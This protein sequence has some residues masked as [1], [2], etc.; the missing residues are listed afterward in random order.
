MSRG[1][2]RAPFEGFGRL[3]FLLLQLLGLR[4][5]LGLWLRPPVSGSLSCGPS[6][7]YTY[8]R[9][10]HHRV[11]QA[12]VIPRSAS[13]GGQSVDV[14]VAC[15]LVALGLQA[16]PPVHVARWLETCRASVC[17]PGWVSPDCPVPC[18]PGT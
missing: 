6:S 12:G 1:R 7:K 11:I 17:L 2:G 13:V 5:A 8:H 10:W 15:R 16:G 3:A 14:S 4:A 9:I 18:S